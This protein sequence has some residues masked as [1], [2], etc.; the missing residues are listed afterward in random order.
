M[1]FQ[2]R[3]CKQVLDGDMRN[4]ANRRNLSKRGYRSYCTQKDR[5]TY[6]EPVTTDIVL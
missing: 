4:R 2:C 1:I 3:H 5:T 6:L